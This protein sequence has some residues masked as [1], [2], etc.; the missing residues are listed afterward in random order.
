MTLRVSSTLRDFLEGPDG[1]SAVMVDQEVLL[2]GPTAAMVVRA[3]MTGTKDPAVL[4]DQLENRFGRPEDGD[5][6]AAT[7]AVIDQLVQRGVLADV[8]QA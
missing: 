1:T 8:S 7:A 2:L 3:I 5:A 4:A 6:I